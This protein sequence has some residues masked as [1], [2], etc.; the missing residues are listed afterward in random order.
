MKQ[1]YVTFL[2]PGTFVSE[3]TTREI[4]SWSTQIAKQLAD[5]ITE[6]HGATPYGFYFT[7][8]ENDGTKL[9]SIQTDRSCFYWLGGKIET[10]EEIEARNDPDEKILRSNMRNYGYAAVV[11]NTNSWK[12][13]APLDSDAIVLKY[14]PP[15]KKV[16]TTT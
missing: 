1:H 12:F 2:S 8:R 6:R 16:E 13:T 5:E 9:D 14:T 10:L 11:V 15:K 4:D 3:N 7:T